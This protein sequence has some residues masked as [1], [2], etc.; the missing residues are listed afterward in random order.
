[1]LRIQKRGEKKREERKYEQENKK[2]LE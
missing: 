2:S 1:L